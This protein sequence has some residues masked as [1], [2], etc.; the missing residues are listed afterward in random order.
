M[1]LFNFR[2]I[3]T[4]KGTQA[5]GFEELVCQL[6]LRFPPASAKKYRRIDGAGGDGGVE[7]FWMLEDGSKV[8]YQAKFFT[9]SGDIN[10][11]QMDD[12]VY[13]AIN[14]HPELKKYVVSFACDLTGARTPPDSRKKPMTGWQ[15]WES[16]VAN[17]TS[18]ASSL[19]RRI[20]FDIW[21]QSDLVDLMARPAATGI[22]ELWFNSTELT[23]DW[24][25]SK[26]EVTLSDLDTRF[27]QV[28]H[29]ELHYA[30]VLSG[31]IRNNDFVKSI[32]T[33]AS[34]LTT[35]DARRGLKTIE[36]WNEAGAGSHLESEVEELLNSI[37]SQDYT[38]CISLPLDEWLNALDN[39]INLYNAG[40]ENIY[41]TFSVDAREISE[42]RQAYQKC[43]QL[44]DDLQSLR[45]LLGGPSLRADQ[46]R[47]LL[48]TGEA[49]IGKSHLLANFT[50]RCLSSGIPAIMLLGQYFGSESPETLL[51]RKLEI[52]PA[53]TFEKWLSAL[54]VAAESS[55]ARA[56]IILDAVN[57][58]SSLE[59]L[60]GHLPGLIKKIL[61]HTNL[62]CAISSRTEYVEHLLCEVLPI[63]ARLQCKGFTTQEEKEMAARQYIDK[64]NLVRPAVPWLSKEFTNPLFLK[65][66]CEALHAS[67]ETEFPKG[68][69]GAKVVLRF[70]LDCI[71][72]KLA[73]F[74]SDTHPD[75]V[76]RAARAIA[77]RMARERCDYITSSDLAICLSGVFGSTGP[78]GSKTWANALSGEGLIRLDHIFSTDTDPLVGAEEIYRFS[79]QRFSDQLIAEALLDSTTDI[80]SVFCEDGALRFLLGKTQ[81]NPTHYNLFEPLAMQIPE[82]HP[83]LELYDLLPDS[84]RGEQQCWHMSREFSDS[85]RWRA[86]VAFTSRTMELV[87]EHCEDKLELLIELSILESHPWNAS[88][89]HDW[90]KQLP[91]AR[92]DS[93][94]SN[95]L[96]HETD[97]EDHPLWRLCLWAL[98]PSISRAS[99]GT[100]ELAAYVLVWVFATPHRPFRDLATKAL[101]S[102]FI[103]KPSLFGVLLEEMGACDDPYILE[104]LYGAA[105]G[106]LCHMDSDSDIQTYAE[107][108]FDSVFSAQEV[109]PNLLMR[110]YA[111]G[112]IENA[113]QRGLLNDRIN[114]KKCRP[115]FSSSPP[116]DF[117]S[118]HELE[119]VADQAGGEDI[120]RSCM[121]MEDFRRYEIESHLRVF[122]SEKLSRPRPQ[123]AESRLDQ[124][125]RVT[126]LWTSSQQNAYER[127]LESVENL[128]LVKFLSRAKI[129]WADSKRT[130]LP[131]E[132]SVAD[133]IAGAKEL[134][135]ANEAALKTEL[136]ESQWRKYRSTARPALLSAEGISRNIPSYDVELAS[137][138][139]AHRAYSFGWSRA[140]FKHEVYSGSRDRP[141][142]ERVGKKYQ[143]I[144]LSELM[145]RLTDNYWLVDSMEQMATKFSNI[146]QLGYV[147]DLDPT[148]LGATK[149]KDIGG[150]SRP[151]WLGSLPDMRPL[152][153]EELS[154][155]VSGQDVFPD[156]SGLCEIVDS[157]E[158]RWLQLY[159]FDSTNEDCV[160]DAS[161]SP[162]R[163]SE[164][165]R[166]SAIVVSRMDRDRVIRR[167]CKVCQIDSGTWEPPGAGNRPYLRE[168]PWRSTWAGEHAGSMVSEFDSLHGIQHWR[169]VI[170]YR[171]DSNT[172]LSILERS[173][174]CLPSSWLLNSLS[175]E[176]RPL[177]VGRFHGPDGQLLFQ[178]PSIG[179]SYPAAGIVRKDYFLK[180]LEEQE[181]ECIWVV[182]SERMASPDVDRRKFLR[183]VHGFIAWIDGG[184]W[185]WHVQKDDAL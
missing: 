170:E 157:N 36:T 86:K 118:I 111:I 154:E 141:I 94:W 130:E 23:D 92:R 133:N 48:V 139:I 152:A 175:L 166:V 15:Q 10:W 22:R 147:R 81:W 76:A 33:N 26:F 114:L 46:K 176:A 8:G 159:S 44:G 90:L 35:P 54:N 143:W 67:G 17:W 110:D 39:C 153:T 142:V 72:R 97:W 115:P 93:V 50:G 131:S 30:E 116:S 71:R 3:K 99:G 20:D 179:T 119:S 83:G 56:V 138:W 88:Y 84:H 51:L 11:K 43:I 1:E 127:L 91:L 13:T 120:L 73:R 113:S 59:L 182:G 136:T 38:P 18:Y 173:Q 96:A 144:A 180:I 82:K 75:S 104:R 70:Y 108:T 21:T 27:T 12:S 169:P 183:C 105:F 184:A 160:A 146:L 55:R 19:A 149:V 106:A 103:I 163:R 6:A 45:E 128:N 140:L 89:L 100:L 28:D 129:P 132:T 7:A 181:L 64:R 57:E 150:D 185:K 25:L 87:D 37:Q 174:V 126:S 95:V 134:V 74:Y 68:L 178:D 32:K 107:I 167:L 29:V 2:N 85:L 145:A 69:H 53:L 171:W 123:S 135:R 109:P 98:S 49:G 9:R 162:Y 31:L 78:S 77:R 42:R 58:A 4:Y 63:S 164:W 24:L 151:W 124:F 41:R 5:N 61:S 148:L 40:V 165:V 79:Y 80:E 34:R 158:V 117:P 66:C 161:W 155:W 62:A 177:E 137:L 102:V 112:I 125:K 65:T 60:R 168:F 122:T 156:C 52:N 47:C 121:E 172:D 16:H 101:A 14:C